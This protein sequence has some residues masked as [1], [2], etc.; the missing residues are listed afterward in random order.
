MNPA[1]T[2]EMSKKRAVTTCNVFIFYAIITFV[3]MYMYIKQCPTN[4]TTCQVKYCNGLTL[5][6]DNFGM[7]SSTLQQNRTE[8]STQALLSK[9]TAVN[10][11][12]KGHVHALI[13]RGLPHDK[14]QGFSG[15]R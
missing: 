6:Q 8:R 9:S 4:F 3:Y 2:S 15:P 1:V 12:P 13:Q 7:L 10:R 14:T 11:F 5:C